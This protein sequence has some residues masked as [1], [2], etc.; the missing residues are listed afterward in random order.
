MPT[1][2]RI[3]MHSV[4]GE[5]LG[6]L[7]RLS[8]LASSLE[9]QHPDCDI[10][11]LTESKYGNDVAPSLRM[12]TVP[13]T[14]VL[15]SS[16]WTDRIAARARHSLVRA[17]REL[18][19]A[20]RPGLT[21]HDTLVWR[22][23]YDAARDSSSRQAIV[24]RSRNEIN[25]AWLRLKCTA[26]HWDCVVVADESGTR[27]SDELASGFDAP[28]FFA[29]RVGRFAREGRDRVRS[30]IGLT[31]ADKLIV[32]TPGGG[33]YPDT[34]AFIATAL[35]AADSVNRIRGDMVAVVVAGPLYR[36]R[37][38]FRTQLPTVLV[39]HY[40][41]MPNLLAAC[42]VIIA[43]AGFNT[44]H[45]SIQA[46][47]PT[48]LVP[49]NRGIDSQHARARELSALNNVFA[50]AE[51]IEDIGS[52]L[53]SGLE[54]ECQSRETSRSLADPAAIR[55]LYDLSEVPRDDQRTNDWASRRYV[56]RHL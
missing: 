32:V 14:S 43:R 47:V 49:A 21:I 35:R 13:S 23:L 27:A 5:G 8:S 4:N 40:P 53:K 3:L 17:V 29:G 22:P 10:L 37:L 39:D 42:D 30:Q 45:E 24:L 51:T 2:H 50:V 52:A 33:G 44:V 56:N 31:T 1:R 46:G 41:T 25:A 36:G 55:L 20:Y 26:P 12:I 18:V 28:L 34:D 6:H 54:I 38:I 11:S 16:A 9:E 7:S 19:S 15:R 48:I